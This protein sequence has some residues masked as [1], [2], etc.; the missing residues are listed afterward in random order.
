[1]AV[2]VAPKTMTGRRW[3]SLVV[4]GIR[5]IDL[6]CQVPVGGRLAIWGDPHSGIDV[7]AS[8]V[9]QNVCRR[10]GAKAIFHA[11]PAEQ[12]SEDFVNHLLDKLKVRQWVDGIVP[13][14]HPKISIANSAGP[15]LTVLPFAAGSKGADAWVVLRRSVLDTGRL[16]AVDMQE[17]GSNTPDTAGRLFARHVAAEVA[18]GH[19]GLKRYLT[20][21]FFV[22]EPWT[23][24]PGQATEP[25]HA[26]QRL[27][28]M[29]RESEL[30]A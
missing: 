12:F 5:V 24:R 8:E 29:M 3:K 18:R 15:I 13:G 4:T 21:P 30:T 19:E 20:Q 6:V 1:M 23:S 7:V 28:S 26:K 16:P 10:Y 22:A 25:E 2:R 14:R 11:T 17:S 27:H 9:M